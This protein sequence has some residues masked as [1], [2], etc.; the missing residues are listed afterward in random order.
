MS[1]EPTKT[2]HV[3][4][5][6]E[7]VGY[8][9]PPKHTRFKKGES[10]NPKGRRKNFIPPVYEDPIKTLLRQPIGVAIDLSDKKTPAYMVMLKVLLRNGV[11]KGDTRALQILFNA[12][13][14]LKTILDEK[15]REASEADRQFIE[16]VRERSNAWSEKH[17]A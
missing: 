6:E 12:T 5:D 2:I 15:Q 9:N 8:C 4:D 3:S 17:G 14:A 10:G 11:T 1:T 16:Y 13:D 7:P